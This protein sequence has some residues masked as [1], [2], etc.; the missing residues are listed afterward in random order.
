[1]KRITGAIGAMMIVSLLLS[2]CASSNAAIPFEANTVEVLWYYEVNRLQSPG[3]T[4][5]SSPADLTPLCERTEGRPMG[6][7]TKSDGSPDKTCVDAVAN[8]ADE[9]FTEKFLVVIDF[10]EYVF[11]WGHQVE[12]IGKD[13]TIT[14]KRIQNSDVNKYKAILVFIEISNKYK[15]DAYQVEFV[16]E[17]LPI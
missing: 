1:M 11:Q 4:I 10:E 2:G 6:D 14:I 7:D 9:F 8:Y 17:Y 5:A 13:G 16:E 15:R 12:S 3:I